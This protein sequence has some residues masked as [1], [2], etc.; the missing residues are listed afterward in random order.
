MRACALSFYY[1]GL[2]HGILL[3][4]VQPIP[5][6]LSVAV[7]AK[8]PQ[9]ATPLSLFSSINGVMTTDLDGNPLIPIGISTSNALLSKRQADAFRMLGVAGTHRYVCRAGGTRS[10]KTFLIVTA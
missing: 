2:P 4:S 8:V 3:F 1:G 10:S 9:G 6:E 7:F 5:I